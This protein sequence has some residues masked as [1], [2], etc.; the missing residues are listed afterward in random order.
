[1]TEAETA[2][3]AQAEAEFS[4]FVRHHELRLRQ[5]LVARVGPERAR[6]AVAD[7]LTH[8][9]QHWDRVRGMENPA[10]YVYR[11][12]QSRSRVRRQPVVFPTP[13]PDMPDI[14][15]GLATALGLLPERQRVAV[16]LVHGWGWTHQE[17]ADVMEVGVST[18]RNHLARGLERLR[19]E[20]GVRLDG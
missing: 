1:M 18:I 12:A 9:W 7:G 5:A 17:V 6:D 10:G 19:S 8:A 14:E 20:L 3:A 15:P 16:L 13:G 4:A 2:M 11:V